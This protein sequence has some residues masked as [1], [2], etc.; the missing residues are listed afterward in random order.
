MSIYTFLM[1]NG[2]EYE[3]VKHEA[4]FTCEEAEKMELTIDGVHTKN[5]FLRDRKGGNHYLVIVSYQKSVDLKSLAG[6]IGETK[7]SFGSPERL[8]KYLKLEPGSVS[9][10]GVMNDPDHNVQVVIDKEIWEAS[11]VLCHPLV[12]TA[13]LS[14]SHEGL[15][16]FLCATGH[17]ET[18]I[19]V[20]ERA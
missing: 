3:E 9:I 12:N 15:E 13:T 17:K 5:L 16:L 4:V 11:R 19:D 20:P 10:L 1:D 8:M 14:I 6:V 7:L 18:V 2:I